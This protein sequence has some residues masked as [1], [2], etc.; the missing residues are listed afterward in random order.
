M[1]GVGRPRPG[2]RRHRAD[3]SRPRAVGRGRRPPP[4]RDRAG[5]RIC[6]GSA[7]STS[8]ECC[9]SAGTRVRPAGARGRRSHGS[10][11]GAGRYPL[12]VDDGVGRC[13]RSA[14]RRRR[15]A[16]DLGTPGHVTVSM[17][18]LGSLG[19]ATVLRRLGPGRADRVGRPGGAAAR[20]PALL[21]R[22]P[23]VVRGALLSDHR[24]M[25]PDA[26]EPEHQPERRPGVVRPPLQRDSV[27]PPAE[28]VP[29]ADPVR[30]RRLS[31]TDDRPTLQPEL[32]SGRSLEAPRSSSRWDVL[33]RNRVAVVVV[34]LV[35]VVVV[36]AVGGK[37]AAE[38][39][40]DAAMEQRADELSELLATRPRRT[41]WRSMPGSRSTGSLAQRVR[42]TDGFVN[43]RARR[44]PGVHPL[45]TLRMVGRVHRT[46]PGGLRAPRRDHRRGP[47][48]RRVYACRNRTR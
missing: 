27:V 26:Q 9:P 7:S 33:R 42:D 40:A 3:R 41:S 23:A 11:P 44:R 36:V 1:A 17:S 19:W 18:D 8:N 30:R 35:L 34:G 28:P 39:A 10:R 46:L 25:P 13:S 22:P 6:C 15:S 48:D 29:H 32:L 4:G 31:R 21:G 20:G 38:R 14:D 16:R 43:L 24:A 37:Y 45:P 5:N 12:E 47:Q 2:R